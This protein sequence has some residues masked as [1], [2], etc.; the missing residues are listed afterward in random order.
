MVVTSQSTTKEPNDPESIQKSFAR[1]LEYSLAC[2]RFKFTMQDRKA[3]F[4]W[5]GKYRLGTCGAEKGRNCECRWGQ[6]SS[7][8][9]MKIMQHVYGSVYLGVTIWSDTFHNYHAP[10]HLETYRGRCYMRQMHLLMF[11]FQWGT[12]WHIHNLA[13]LGFLRHQSISICQQCSPI[14][15]NRFDCRMHTGQLVLFCATGCWSHWTTPTP[16]TG[17]RTW[18]GSRSRCN[19]IQG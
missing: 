14:D 4:I 6:S 9:S 5:L 19:F 1:H 12:S 11:R 2:T 13:F 8:H 18:R 7:Q 10:H 15:T 17:N 16:T 3:S